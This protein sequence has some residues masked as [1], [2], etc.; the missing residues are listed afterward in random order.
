M[1]VRR[2]VTMI[3]DYIT[4]VQNGECSKMEITLIGICLF[5]LGVVI[6]MVIAPAKFTLFGS[7][8]GNSGSIDAP[9][10]LL[11]KCCGHKDKHESC[12]CG[13]E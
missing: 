6:G 5:L 9:E 11:E 1:N 4:K 3:K 8:N 12:C 13:D 10:K 2:A 7:F